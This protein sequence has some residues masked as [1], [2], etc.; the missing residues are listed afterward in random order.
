MSTCSLM[1]NSAFATCDLGVKFFFFTSYETKYKS[2]LGA[3][4]I[5]LAVNSLVF[6]GLA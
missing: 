4:L 1:I 6:K 5:S 2:N 3:Y